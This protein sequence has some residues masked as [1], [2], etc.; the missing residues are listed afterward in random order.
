[1]IRTEELRRIL[2]SEMEPILD[3]EMDLMGHVVWDDKFD[4]III[5]I[6]ELIKS[7]QN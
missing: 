3:E 1:M 5:R 4:N 7:K 6:K 2:E